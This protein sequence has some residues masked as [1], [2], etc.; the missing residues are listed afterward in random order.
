[1]FIVVL[2]GKLTTLL[3][4]CINNGTKCLHHILLY[5]LKRVKERKSQE[6]LLKRLHKTSDYSR[7]GLNGLQAGDIVGWNVTFL[8]RFLAPC[9]PPVTLRI[10]QDLQVLPLSKTKVLVCPRIVIIQRYE[11]SGGRGLICISAL[12][13]RRSRIRGWSGYW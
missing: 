7:L 2:C 11:Y 5:Q 1:M 8:F 4:K 9:Q 6:L 12:I 3:C 10:V 13:H